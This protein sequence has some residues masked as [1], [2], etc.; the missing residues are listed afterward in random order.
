M[1]DEAADLTLTLGAMIPVVVTAR[2][3]MTE[4][5]TLTTILT[6]TFVWYSEGRSE[7]RFAYGGACYNWTVNRDDAFATWQ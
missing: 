1:A 3:K 6:P 5:M 7:D 2:A 4:L